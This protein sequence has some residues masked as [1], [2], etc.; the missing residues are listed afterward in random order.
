MV[1]RLRSAGWVAGISA[2]IGLVAG[3]GANVV[4]DRGAA[5]GA[6]ASGQGGGT[7]TT[8]TSTTGTGGGATTSTNS[9][10][11]PASPPQAGAVCAGDLT[12]TYGD[13]PCP[14][15]FACLGTWAQA[16]ECP[17]P[18]CPPGQPS[19][20]EACSSEGQSCSYDYQCSGAHATCQGGAWW[21]DEYGVG[22]AAI[23]PGEV[24]QEGAFCDVC[25]LPPACTY[26]IPGCSPTEAHCRQDGSWQVGPGDCNP[27]PPMSFCGFHGAQGECQG[28][29]NCR[30]IVPGCTVPTLPAAGCF[31]KDDCAGD[32][33]CG[34]QQC[35]AASIDPCWDKGCNACAAKAMLCLP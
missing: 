25:C 1:M 27:P 28:D 7:T 5:T 32:F 4:V 2:A 29:A 9:P 33:E 18:A 12:C 21:I 3:C 31:A 22:C 13:G 20:G 14:E 17:Q 15:M 24:P 6:G 19:S 11:C 30:W 8:S 34:G 23:C 26:E 10:L 16:G 35:A